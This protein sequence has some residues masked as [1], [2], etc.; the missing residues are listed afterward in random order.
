MNSRRIAIHFLVSHSPNINL[1]LICCAWILSN[2][3]WDSVYTAPLWRRHLVRTPLNEWLLMTIIRYCSCPVHR[4]RRPQQER[5]D[6]R[7][8]CIAGSSLTSPASCIEKLE[9]DYEKPQAPALA[10]AS[11]SNCSPRHAIFDRAAARV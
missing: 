11:Q 9:E 10:I 8:R 4:S 5:Q 2:L 1:Y 7:P 6:E 3:P